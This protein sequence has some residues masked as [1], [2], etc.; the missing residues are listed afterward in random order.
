[1]DIRDHIKQKREE[2]AKAK[3]EADG[4]LDLLDK[5]PDLELHV[6]RWKRERYSSAQ[7]N[8]LTTDCDIS[9]NCGCC[10]DSPLEVWPYVQLGDVRVYS[11]PACFVVG[12]RNAYG[13]GER[14]YDGWQDELEAE[15]IPDE[16][17][18]KVGAYLSAN[19]ETSEDDDDDDDA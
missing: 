13:Y 9:H 3:A 7:A 16:V 2:A 5:F 19:P 10:P 4:A 18:A 6:N 14:P 12:E 15:G 1:M 11:K 8:P 17:I